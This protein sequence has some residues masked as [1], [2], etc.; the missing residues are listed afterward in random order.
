MDK[1]SQLKN[2]V[3][4]VNLLIFIR[5]ITIIIIGIGLTLSVRNTKE[6]LVFYSLIVFCALLIIEIIITIGISVFK[7][8]IHYENKLK[9]NKK[10][11]R[12]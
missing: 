12:K 8:K 9:L 3:G 5:W 4:L 1:E 11:E 10:S 6:F 2:Y 7:R